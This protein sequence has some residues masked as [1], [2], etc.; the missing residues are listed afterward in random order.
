MSTIPINDT[1]PRV[2]YTATAGQTIFIF[3]FWATDAADLSVYVDGV[4]LTPVAEFSATGLLSPAGGNVTLGAPTTEGQVVTIER[5]IPFERTSEFQEGGTFKASILNLELSKQ[6]AMMQQLKRD[7]DRKIGPSPSSSVVA[8]A[9][10]L[11]DPI[12]GRA[13]V[14]DGNDGS[15]RTSNASIDNLDSALT[16]VEAAAD[17]ATASASTASAEAA[18]ATA[19]RD[20]AEAARDTAVAS[21]GMSKVTPADTTPA[22]LNSK[23][24]AG[25]LVY[26][27]VSNPG[28]NEVVSVGVSVADQITAE[29]GMSDAHAMTPL[30]VLQ[31]I[32]KNQTLIVE[33]DIDESN[34]PQVVLSDLDLTTGSYVLDLHGFAPVN[35]NVGAQ[36]Q[37]STDN[38]ST[39]INTGIYYDRGWQQYSTSLGDT[40]PFDGQ[41][42]GR[43]HNIAL[44]SDV[45]HTANAMT[46]ELRRQDA[47][48]HFRY[49]VTSDVHNS[50]GNMYA[51]ELRGLVA[52]TTPINALRL[53]AADGNN[54]DYIKGTLYRRN[55]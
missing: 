24:G 1:T 35:A 40:S 29:A 12:D 14:F 13:I 31:S 52:T 37:V 54:I 53:F 30:K 19:A 15:L 22:P 27:S 16:A 8:G 23:L 38:G 6:L 7:I 28:G 18:T 10:V 48:K 20:E 49:R 34:V 51:C 9:L 32:L 2:Q 41:T 39:W 4:A 33:G 26:K 50:A 43:L 21:I 17:S 55:G 11:P 47:G 3:P 44:G 45:A 5:N 25:P 46:L 36:L 42:A